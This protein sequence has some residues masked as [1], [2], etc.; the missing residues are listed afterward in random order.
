MSKEETGKKDGVSRRQRVLYA[1]QGGLTDEYVKDTL[2]IDILDVHRKLRA[3]LDNLSKHTHIEEETFN[4]SDEVVDQF[5]QETLAAVMELFKAIE[6]S[7]EKLVSALHEKID[8][9]IIDYLI[10]ETIGSIDQLSTHHYI[11]DI[12]TDD[13]IIVGIDNKH[14]KFKASGTIDCN[15]QYGSDSDVRE[16]IGIVFDHSF[17]FSCELWSS[18]DNPQDIQT[19]E[20]A[21]G[22]DT[23]YWD[24]RY[25]DE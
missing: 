23:S 15:L 19:D 7:R 5:V 1:I 16:D 8:N 22:V 24:D 9:S 11:K 17:P 10:S 20:D 2:S 18:V 14:V 25:C 13:V 21:I 6:T 3:A 4:L 12:C